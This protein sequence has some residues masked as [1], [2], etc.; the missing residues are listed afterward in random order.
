MTAFH[1]R[2]GSTQDLSTARAH[3]EESLAITQEVGD[4]CGEAWRWIGLAR[5]ATSERSFAEAQACFERGLAIARETGSFIVE[6]ATGEYVHGL[7][8]VPIHPD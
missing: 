5:V 8:D 2:P 7:F 4:R 3:H 1:A 6:L